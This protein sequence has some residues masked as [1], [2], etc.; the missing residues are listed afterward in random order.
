MQILILSGNTGGGHNSAAM[1]VKDYFE[2]EGSVCDIRDSLAFWGEL[3]SDIISNGHVFIYK[4]TPK[5]FGFGYR[6]AE[7]HP[8]KEN[9]SSF[10]YK[11]FSKGAKKLYELLLQ[12]KYDAIV[13]THV[14]SGILATEVKRRYIPQL[15]IY[16]VATDY[17][18]S[19]GTP[20]IDANAFFI[21]HESLKDEFI[22]AHIPENRIIPSGIP[23]RNSFYTKADLHTA[24]KQLGLPLNKH[25][26]LL[27]CGSMGCGPI[28]DLAQKIST[29]MPENSHLAIICGSNKSLKKEISEALVASNTT[30]VGFTKRMALYMD[31]ATVAITKPGG[32]SSTEAL[33]KGL[34]LVLIDAV[35]GCETHNMEFLTSGGFAETGNTPLEL[36]SKVLSYITNE[37]KREAAKTAIAH[38][39]GHN[40]AKV[41]YD[42]ITSIKR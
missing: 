11:T 7:N 3:Q 26:I 29:L 40:A 19:P 37:Q 17:T 9:Y 42:H 15:K 35:P 38:S 14:F 6:F 22:A 13:C 39:F 1:A 23:V 8:A 25:I 12:K 34:P 28:K 2:L 18:C 31:A 10:L 30:I 16:F 20:E 27:M 21:P 4:K 32:L 5:L 41:I 36:T 24:K 33:V